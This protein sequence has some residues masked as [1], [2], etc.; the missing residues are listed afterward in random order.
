[1]EPSQDNTFIKS[2][3]SCIIL[4]DGDAFL[5]QLDKGWHFLDRLVM[6]LQM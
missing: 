1:M 4:Y 3:L 6:N 2:L 5:H